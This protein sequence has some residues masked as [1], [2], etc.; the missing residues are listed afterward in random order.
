LEVWR[1]QQVPLRQPE[2]LLLALEAAAH[3]LAQQGPLQQL[4]PLLLALEHF[5]QP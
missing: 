5:A 4:E 3:Y 1:A 2:P